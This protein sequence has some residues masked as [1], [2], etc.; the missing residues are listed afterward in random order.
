[1]SR[2]ILVVDKKEIEVKEVIEKIMK[3]HGYTNN[4]VEYGVAYKLDMEYDTKRVFEA[5]EDWAMSTTIKEFGMAIEIDDGGFGGCSFYGSP[6]KFGIIK[7]V[8][9]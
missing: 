1:M 2:V 5:M 7:K 3:V 9:F 4:F 8:T 6:E